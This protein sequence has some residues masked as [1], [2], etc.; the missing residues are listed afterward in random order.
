M[1]TRGS[2]RRS[3]RSWGRRGNEPRRVSRRLQS[4]RGWGHGETGTVFS[5]G[6]GAGGADG[7]GARGGPSVAVGGD[8]LDRGE[9]GVRGGDA[10]ELGAAGRTGGRPAA[11]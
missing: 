4:L 8:H 1:P 3:R 11:G 10:P 6:A 7:D 9:A 5:G 2:S